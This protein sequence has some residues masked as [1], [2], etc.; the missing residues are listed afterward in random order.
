MTG[1]LFLCHVS[2]EKYNPCTKT[3]RGID[4]MVEEENCKIYV[5]DSGKKYR[6]EDYKEIVNECL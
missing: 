3:G 1:D 5:P 2:R 6:D 4:K